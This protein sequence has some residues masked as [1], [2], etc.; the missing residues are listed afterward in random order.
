[1]VGVNS[2]RFEVGKMGRGT[3]PRYREMSP[4]WVRLL[5]LLNYHVTPPGEIAVC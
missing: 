1:M 5:W 3:H 2:L 4:F